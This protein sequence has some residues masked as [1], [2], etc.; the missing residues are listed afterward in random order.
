MSHMLPSPA[1][2]GVLIRL[3]KLVTSKDNVRR[4]DRLIDIEALADDIAAHGVLQ[5]LNVVATENGRFAVCAGARRHAALKLLHK[6][7]R[8]PLSFGVPCK[9]VPADSAVEASLSENIQRVAMHPMDEAEAFDAL[10]ARG[11]DID[12]IALR[13]GATVRHVE[14]RLA[15]A[16]LSPLIRA[17]YKRDE[18]NL[19][20][21]RAFCLSDDHAVQERVFKGFGKPIHSAHAVR[22][23][24]TQGRT[25]ANDR[26]A[27]FVGVEAYQAAGGRLFEDLFE[28]DLILFEDG[29][30][31]Q[32]LAQ[33]KAEALREVEAE[34]WGWSEINLA[35]THI[36]GCASERL[37]A[38]LGKLKAAEKRRVGVLD[39]EIARLDA[40]IEALDDGD[41]DEALW[42][43]RETLD[44]ER[45]QIMNSA[46]VFELAEMAH[47][48]IL[49]GVDRDGKAVILRG[50]I[51]RTD[52]KTI[53]K[54]RRAS[55]DCA[56]APEDG[57]APDA[58]SGFSKALMRDLT[59]ARTRAIREG[60]ASSPHIA[61]ALVVCMFAQQSAGSGDLVGPDIRSTP[62]DFDDDQLF[63]GLKGRCR[64]PE[65]LDDCLA[66]DAADLFKCLAILVA[67]TI[68]LTH[69]GFST[70]D[71]ARQV[72]G[73]AIASAIDLD[74][75]AHWAPDAAF[76]ARVSRSFGLE[77]L[78]GA[79]VFPEAERDRKLKALAK[80]KKADFAE[81]AARAMS[82][83]RWLP[84][85]LVTP[86]R[87]G[88]LEIAEPAP[89]R[90]AKSA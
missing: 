61:L 80:L 65:T 11:L 6:Q 46:R 24:L 33:E 9:I 84:D 8:I 77:A 63:Q 83:A 15:L 82:G 14:Q 18:L 88:A 62:R 23:A 22:N 41:C 44:N 56:G 35:G 21:A 71:Q 2:A 34:G 87:A 5:N 31:L 38:N 13:Y 17:A 45:D 72:S 53:E 74:M 29:D 48:G 43:Q 68:D 37:R 76:W 50:L 42:D 70:Q 12:A 30:I 1:D 16:R 28:T 10:T 69:E 52:L 3:S 47:A 81:A 90:R 59:L 64:I 20:V 89:K 60:V 39:G 78:R 79:D 40:E 36:E 4:T 49:V 27:V 26:L 32:R 67:E 7:G 58:G 54:V 55:T 73:D 75:S 85:C 86:L 57:S 66:L 51:R 25:P 19:D